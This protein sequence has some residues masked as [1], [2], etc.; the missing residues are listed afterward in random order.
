MEQMRGR[1]MAIGLTLGLI[2][3][4]STVAAAADWTQFGASQGH[5]RA[6][7]RE[8][9]IGTDTVLTLER[10][11]SVDLRVAGLDNEVSAGPRSRTVASSPRSRARRLRRWHRAVAG[12]R[13]RPRDGGRAVTVDVPGVVSWSP[14]VLGDTVVVA[15]RA[16]GTP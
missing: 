1:L 4:S 15:L 10:A 9:L 11:W 5:T 8:Q 13:P 16:P 14:A 12:R 3:A 6:R 2:A 7:P